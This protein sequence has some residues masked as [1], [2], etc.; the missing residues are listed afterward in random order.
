MMYLLPG[1]NNTAVPLPINTAKEGCHSSSYQVHCQ[2]SQSVYCQHSRHFASQNASKNAR[3]PPLRL[4]VHP[5]AP[6]SSTKILYSMYLM[7]P[8]TNNTVLLSMLQRKRDHPTRQY[9]VQFQ[10][11]QNTASTP[12][13]SPVR[14]SRKYTAVPQEHVM[15]MSLTGHAPAPHAVSCTH[16]APRVIHTWYLVHILCVMRKPCCLCWYDAT[17]FFA[18]ILYA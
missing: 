6:S 2:H 15:C 3:L 12:G 10:N 16:L 18:V 9:P 7:L 11:S 8:G 5:P 1:R 4:R 13:N 17:A 14:V